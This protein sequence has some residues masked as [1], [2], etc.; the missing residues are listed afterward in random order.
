M[1]SIKICR[2][3]LKGNSVNTEHLCKN[4]KVSARHWWNPRMSENCVQAEGSD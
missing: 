1:S 2:K 3:Y 4:T